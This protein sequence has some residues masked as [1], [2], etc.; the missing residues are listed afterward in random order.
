M[1]KINLA[2]K[3][4]LVQEHWHPH[5]IAELDNYDIK[6]VKIAGEFVWHKHDDADEM[7]LIIK[8]AMNMEMRDRTVSLTAGEMIVVPKGIEHRPTAQDECEIVLFERQGLV[9]TG[10]A[11]KNELTRDQ[12]ERI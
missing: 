6:V 12:L 8:G 9:N 7:F 2:E 11:D 1:D 5:L 3:F 4:D 10:D